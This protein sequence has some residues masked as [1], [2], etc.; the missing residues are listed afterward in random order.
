MWDSPMF[1]Q[2]GHRKWLM[3][4]V[5]PKRSPPAESVGLALV[6]RACGVI[7]AFEQFQFKAK[8]PACLTE[9]LTLHLDSR[10]VLQT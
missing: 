7:E 5:S 9:S 6:L 1:E 2:P 3:G 4:T 8:L 10:F